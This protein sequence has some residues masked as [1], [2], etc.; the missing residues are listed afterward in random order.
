MKVKLSRY[1][2]VAGIFLIGAIVG[3]IAITIGVAI[4]KGWFSRKV[5]YETNLDNAEGIHPGT[6]V[7]ISGLRAG[8]VSEVE[9]LSNE[10]VMVRVKV[11]EK[12]SQRVKEDSQIQVVRPFLI[13]E[14]VLD[15]SIGSDEAKTI[16][17]GGTIGSRPSVDLMDLVSGKRMNDFL[18]SIN[19]FVDSF[20]TLAAA[21]SDPQRMK[22]FVKTLD[23][24]E[25][26]VGNLNSMSM[27]VAK[28]TN[29][30]NRKGR[31]ELMADGL[32]QLT[33]ELKVILPEISAGAPQLG[34][35]LGQLVTSMTI[36]AKEF[37]S[38][39][40]ALR[41]IAP[42]LPHSS[43]RALEALDEAVVLLKAMQKSFFL[44]GNV[45][46]VREEESEREPASEKSGD[47]KP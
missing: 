46:E 29:S 24:I 10:Q 21:F 14:K 28:V 27:E 20:R 11:L 9:L 43:R 25:P 32:A 35:Q 5:S 18:T 30:L 7:Q 33:T 2:R 39:T 17:E 40:P 34:T 16:A 31:M 8:E 26:L 6:V 1:E 19:G 47:S 3:S 38:L 4:R 41:E 36:L 13:G 23:Q 37:E 42:D 22:S 44:R 45:K 12:F 15:L